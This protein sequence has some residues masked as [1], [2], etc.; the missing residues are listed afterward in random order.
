MQLIR[1]GGYAICIVQTSRLNILK[2]KVMEYNFKIDLQAI[3]AESS[4]APK[5]RGPKPG[6]RSK[7]KGATPSELNQ[8]LA[9]TLRESELGDSK[10][11]KAYINK[12]KMG[13]LRN[14]LQKIKKLEAALVHDCKRAEENKG[15]L[16]AEFTTRKFLIKFYM[17]S[18]GGV[19]KEIIAKQGL[20]L[21]VNQEKEV[22]RIQE[23]QAQVLTPQEQEE[24]KLTV[25]G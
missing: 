4:K 2:T 8:A 24:V 6:S 25:E 12:Q 18:E 10:F 3:E 14:Q 22:K 9:E 20:R 13:K 21:Y 1:F 23:L 5:K 19:Y 17:N 11:L 7:S 15:D 16:I